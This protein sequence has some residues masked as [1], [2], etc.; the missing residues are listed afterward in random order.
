MESSSRSVQASVRRCAGVAVAALMTA[1]APSC[2]VPGIVSATPA[3]A[4]E[5][6]AALEND[7]GVPDRE[8][9]FDTKASL[10]NWHLYEGIGHAGNGK[11]T[12]KAISVSDGVL[13]ITGD[14]SGDSGGMGWNAGQHFGRWE[15]CVRSPQSAPGYHSVVLLW[16][17]AEDWPVGGEVDFMEAI[18]PTRQVVEGWMHYGADDR[19]VGAQVSVD[20]TQWHA[21]AVEWTPEKIT[22]FLDG[23]PW[24]TST[25]TANFPP[26]SLH[27]CLQVDDFGGDI[28]AGGSQL[29]DWV[30]QYS[31]P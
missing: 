18:E 29:V 23:T 20:A 2:G 16:P 28:A 9:G 26:R 7:W 10:S 19:R 22:Y 3:G 13:T 17:D 25:N 11:R 27:L 6:T 31:L 4:C 30:R 8:D 14:G 21:W 15:V 12:P 24:W 5:H 1:A